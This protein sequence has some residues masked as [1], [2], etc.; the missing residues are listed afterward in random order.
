VWYTG[1]MGWG[2]GS[3]EFFYP[4]LLHTVSYD[5][6]S[7]CTPISSAESHARAIVAP[8]RRTDLLILGLTTPMTPPRFNE[9]SQQPSQSL[10]PHLQA[11][12]GRST[13]FEFGLGHAQSSML[14]CVCA[15]QFSHHRLR[16]H[17]ASYPY[18]PNS[19]SSTPDNAAC[20]SFRCSTAWSS[21]RW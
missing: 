9:C 18:C 7:P 19:P 8:S 13:R 12:D 17:V 21:P 15:G 11:H 6:K 10:S 5:D 1:W 3:G 4:N 14:S 16:W 2:I 20:C